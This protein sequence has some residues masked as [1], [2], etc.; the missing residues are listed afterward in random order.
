MI[1]RVINLLHR[2]DRNMLY[3]YLCSFVQHPMGLYSKAGSKF[4]VL[5]GYDGEEVTEQVLY[6]TVF[7]DELRSIPI[8]TRRPIQIDEA[9]Y[10]PHPK[11]VQ[12]WLEATR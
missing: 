1:N 3:N 9:N 12:I 8:R 7:G 11:T 4:Y 10:L 6:E 2:D 5:V